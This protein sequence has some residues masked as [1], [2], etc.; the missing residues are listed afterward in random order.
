MTIMVVNVNVFI[1]IVD[2]NFVAK[3]VVSIENAKKNLVFCSLIRTFAR[4]FL[5]INFHCNEYI[6]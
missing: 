3:V 5:G 6:V 4:D 1:I 2:K